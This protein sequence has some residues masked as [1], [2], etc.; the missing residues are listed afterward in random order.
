L[1]IRRTAVGRVVRERQKIIS[2]LFLHSTDA[3]ALAEP[4]NGFF[5]FNSLV[6]FFIS[7]FLVS[8]LHGK[9]AAFWESN[10]LNC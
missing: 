6:P 3:Q 4:Q 2:Q 10:E 7:F 5:V 8:L 9:G 1:D